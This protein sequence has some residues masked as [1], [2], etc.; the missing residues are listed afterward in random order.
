M[1]T[2]VAATP[3]SG[4]RAVSLASPQLGSSSSSVN[5]TQSGVRLRSS[6]A[7]LMSSNVLTLLVG[8]GTVVSL[9]VIA[10][11][12]LLNRRSKRAENRLEGRKTSHVTE[13]LQVDMVDRRIRATSLDHSLDMEEMMPSPS[14]EGRVDAV[15]R[16]IAGLSVTK[17]G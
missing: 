11:V 4:I 16:P 3:Q 5:I 2:V 13:V 6:M 9:V 17:I 1:G 12:L 8:T 7:E 14:G 10:A 15:L